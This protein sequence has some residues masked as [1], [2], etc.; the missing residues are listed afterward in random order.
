MIAARTLDVTS[1]RRLL[2]G[3]ATTDRLPELPFVAALRGHTTVL[4]LLLDGGADIDAVDHLRRTP[5]L[6]AVDEGQ[7]EV[8]RL[9][10]KRGASSEGAPS[11]DRRR[12]RP[13]IQAASFGF[14]EIAQLLIEAGANLESS[15]GRPHST[16]LSAAARA[17]HLS[18]VNLLL[19]A[20]ADRKAT[21]HGGV[22]AADVAERAGQTEIA[23]LLR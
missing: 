6:L 13:L 14:D 3:G 7:T 1:I 15:G 17:G 9:L 8:V 22:T 11:G 18:T 5:L 23:A 10:L 19:D 2:E 16:P 4:E 12:T 20:G 21:L